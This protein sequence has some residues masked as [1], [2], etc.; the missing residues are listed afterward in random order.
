MGTLLFVAGVLCLLF[1]W[2]CSNQKNTA[3]TRFYHSVNT[4]YNIHFNAN[5]AYKEALKNKQRN[6]DDNLSEMLYVFP[7]N[8]DTT[9]NSFQSGTGNFTTTIDKT[10]KAIK[11]HSIKTKPRRDPKR[12]NDTEYQAWLQQK[13]YTPFMDQVWLLLA[14]A[15]FHD[16]NYL[17]AITT[18]M[19]IT[20][21]YGSQPD[22]VAESNLWIARAYTEMGWMYEAGNILHKM[23]LAGGPPKS[24]EGLYASVKANY[25]V[26]TGEYQEAIPYLQSAIKKEKDKHQKLRMRYLLAQLYE[27]TGD[28]ANAYKAFGDVQG[29]STPYKYTLNAKLQQALLDTSKGDKTII[30]SLTKMAKS[31]K[32]KEYKDQL[33]YTIGNVYLQ[34]A[35]T[36]KAIEN[37]REAVKE[38]SRNGYDKMM[39]EVALGD[40]YF[41]RREFVNAQPF[42]QGPLTQLK[43]SHPAYP[44]VALRSNVLDELVVHV[45]TVEEQDSL[46][47]VARLPED[48]RLALINKKIETLKE[49]E[50]K[51][52][53]EEE[54]LKQEEQRSQRLTS[55][56]DLGNNSLLEPTNNQQ[57]TPVIPQTS[58]GQQ[59]NANA[60]YFYNEQAVNQGKIAFKKQWGNRK[61]EDDWRRKNKTSTTSSFDDF[62]GETDIIAGTDSTSLNPQTGEVEALESDSVSNNVYSVEYYLQQLPLTEE[63]VTESN[64]LIENA[65]FNMGLIYKDKLQNIPLAI[66]AFNTDIERFPQTPNLEEI[67]YQLLLIYMQAGNKAMM[68]DYRNRLLSEFTEGVY[69]RALSD[70]DYEWNFR[71]LPVIQDS[72][73][74]AAY[75]AYQKADVQAVRSNY[76]TMNEKYPLTTLMPK[77]ALLNALS[78][79]QSRDIQAL[80]DNLKELTEKYPKSDVTSLASQILERIKDGRGLLSDGTPIT[81]FDWSKAYLSDSTM[82]DDEGKAVLFTDNLDTEYLLL[83]MYKSNTIDRNELLYEVADYNFSNYVIQT[84]DLSFETDPPYD[85]LQMKGFATF[86]NVRSYLNK[87][88]APGGLMSK[89][90]T[91]IMVVPI[92]VENYTKALPR[93]GMAEYMAFVEEHYESLLPQL[94]SYWNNKEMEQDV[95]ATEEGTAEPEEKNVQPQV[96]EET[97]RPVEAKPATKPEKPV[98]DKEI[99]ADDLLTDEQLEKVGQVNDAIEK[100]EDIMS[101]PVDGIKGLFNQYKN[102]QKLT[103][104]ERDALKEQQRQEKER[105]KEQKAIEKARQDSVRRV[106]KMHSDSIANAE[107]VLQDSIKAA[108]KAKKEEAK[109]EEQR[110]KDAEKAAIKA[111]ED[112]QKRKENERKEHQRQQEQRLR[113]RENERKEKEKAREELRKQKEREQEERRRQREKERKELEKAREQERKEKERQAE[114][115]RRNKD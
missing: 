64:E 5:E 14:R 112:E 80:G 63:A 48:E 33:Y 103:K 83:L 72:L 65:L 4:R 13:E 17:R 113:D 52:R 31:S 91:T 47:Y 58:F 88:F 26:R 30:S 49:E 35:D 1:T 94:I 69:A 86:A 96:K 59:N 98:N 41:D 111:R 110:K 32:N 50:E 54:R 18:F 75:E 99:T 70:A 16:G 78:Y 44:R 92:S 56:G 23:E 43:K 61:L 40:L 109:L 84:Y 74:N 71:H 27:E 37:Y 73:Y 24:H 55:W 90:D 15:E 108:E 11:L 51:R 82:V 87:A 8:S 7:D 6:I 100:V 102:R 10:T 89:I 25:L 81:D 106:E 42:Y 66:D 115:R 9:A 105:K 67:Y 107:K 20:K 68:A 45:K 28:K 12:R 97:K 85:I 38:S 57:I 77:F 79:A 76:R 29:G 3:L 104:E 21:I 60:F 95:S 34:S 62:G 39:A 53:K 36:I 46:Q 114:E 93:M 19:Y 2:S 22:I 101:N